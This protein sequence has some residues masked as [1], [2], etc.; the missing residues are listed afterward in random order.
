MG[1]GGEGEALSKGYWLIKE[2]MGTLP[3]K[4][5]VEENAGLGV[6]AGG[7]MGQE[8]LQKLIL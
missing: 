5:G 2:V 8:T 4:L 7:G 3:S 6:L 1:G